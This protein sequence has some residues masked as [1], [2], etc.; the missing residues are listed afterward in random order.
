MLAGVL[1]ELLNL[2]KMQIPNSLPAPKVQIKFATSSRDAYLPVATWYDCLWKSFFKKIRKLLE[3]AGS[4]CSLVSSGEPS[5]TETA[6]PLY[7]TYRDNT[8]PLVASRWRCPAAGKGEGT[9]SGQ[10]GH[11]GTCRGSLI[12]GLVQAVYKTCCHRVTWF[13][14]SSAL[15]FLHTLPLPLLALISSLPFIAF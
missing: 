6:L 9:R 11:R 12:L 8:L 1:P 7:L 13:E 4:R 5:S 15:P 14:K 2:V 3:I 10:T